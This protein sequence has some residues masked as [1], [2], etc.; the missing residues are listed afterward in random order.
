MQN[1]AFLWLGKKTSQISTKST[2][3][4]QVCFPRET[5]TSDK[6]GVL[7]LDKFGLIIYFS[8][9]LRCEMSEPSQQTY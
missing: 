7:L 9:I 8:N 5:K 6:S 1:I 3:N 2:H 4:K